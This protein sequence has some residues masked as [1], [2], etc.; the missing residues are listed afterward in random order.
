M[1]RKHL[2]RYVQEFAG[3]QSRRDLG[4]MD[5]IQLMVRTMVG[6]RLNYRELT[7]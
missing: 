2:D 7:K 1:S 6:W 3:C 5:Q 4:M